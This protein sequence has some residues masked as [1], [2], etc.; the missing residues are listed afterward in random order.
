[1]IAAISEA[2][3][4][5]QTWPWPI[6]SAV[7]SAT[8]VLLIGY[9]QIVRPWCRRLKL[10]R[11]FEAYFLITSLGRFPMNYVLQDD[12]EHFVKELVVPAHS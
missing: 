3:E 6:A 9:V 8:A 1:V 4:A 10:K 5:I 2:W 12:Q 11:P 7:F